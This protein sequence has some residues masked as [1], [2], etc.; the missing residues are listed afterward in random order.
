[1]C[2]EVLATP[3]SHTAFTSSS[4]YS[5]GYGA[6]YAKLNRRGGAGGWSPV[7]ADRY[8]WL[9]VDLGT[10]KQVTFIATQGRYSSSDWTTQYRLLYSNS[11][12]E[13]VVRHDLQHAIITRYVRFI[14][15][16][17][18]EE[19]RIGLRVEVYGCSYWEDVINFEG[20]GVISYRFKMK[21]MKI[22]KDIISL[23]FK[24]TASNGS[25]QYGSILGHT[26]VTSGSL[27]DDDHWHSVIIERY[28]RN[29]NF[30][31]DRHTQHFR[32]NGEFDHLDLDYEIS[33]GGMPFSAKPSTGGRENFRNLTFSCSETHSFPLFFNATSFLRLPG[34]PDS[35]TLSVSLSFRTWNPSGLLL[36]TALADG[37]VEVGLTQG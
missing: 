33:F 28:R 5:G 15:L 14:P 29:V 3:L 31:L 22:L 37:V 9:Q 25:N 21:K 24:T 17:W 26:S 8:Q 23:K 11:N 6:G 2:D 18:S 1:K 35:D 13:S 16:E 12:S 34:L 27:L 19:G 20:Q 10:R 36:Y 7:D 30:T 32:T 4:V